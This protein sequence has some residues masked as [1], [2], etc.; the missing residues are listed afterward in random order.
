[1]VEGKNSTHTVLSRLAE[2]ESFVRRPTCRFHREVVKSEECSVSV[3]S[4][5]L[6][7]CLSYYVSRYHRESGLTTPHLESYSST[8]PTGVK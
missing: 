3:L 1:M 2:L 5:V 4:Q 7:L 6:Q 8:M